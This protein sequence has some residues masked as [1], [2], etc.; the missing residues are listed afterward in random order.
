MFLPDIV[1]QYTASAAGIPFLNPYLNSTGNFSHGVNFAVG[2]STSLPEKK[3]ATISRTG[4]S[5]DAQLN[6]MSTF[7][8]SWCTSH[9]RK[10]V[11]SVSIQNFLM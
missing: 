2:G 3:D 11:N 10:L 7:F 9:T 5:L 8:A 4:R 1:L 6:W